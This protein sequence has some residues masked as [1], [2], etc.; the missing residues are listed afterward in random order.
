MGE[1]FPVCPVCCKTT[2]YI[3]AITVK[4]L[5]YHPNCYNLRRSYRFKKKYGLKGDILE[6]DTISYGWTIPVQLSITSVYGAIQR[7]RVIGRKA[8][9]LRV[10]SAELGIATEIIEKMKEGGLIRRPVP[11]E[12]DSRLTGY[13]WRLLSMRR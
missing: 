1:I 10:A 3:G 5:N 9:V 11:I 4:G 6:R 7:F 2:N 12:V 13:E 8:K